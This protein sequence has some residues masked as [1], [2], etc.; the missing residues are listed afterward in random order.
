M[1]DYSAHDFYFSVDLYNGTEKRCYTRGNY[2][3]WVR[4][5]ISSDKLYEAFT[6]KIL[7]GSN[8]LRFTYVQA[9]GH[10]QGQ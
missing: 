1:S 3:W 2:M 5:D 4:E 6:N 9:N 8:K 7:K 10:E